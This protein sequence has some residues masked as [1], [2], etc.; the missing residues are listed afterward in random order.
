MTPFGM[1]ATGYHI[2]ASPPEARAIGYRWQGNQ[3]VREP[4]MKDGAFGAM[5]GVETSASDYAKW[6]AFLLQAWPA[7]DGPEQ[8]PVRRSTLREIVT[9]ANFATAPMRNPAIGGA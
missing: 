5:G 4:D 6:V 1:S 3:W 8:G 9:G 2:F 7:R